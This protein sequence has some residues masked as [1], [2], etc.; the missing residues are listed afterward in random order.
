MEN[1]KSQE[2]A[3]QPL[4]LRR[5]YS[6]PTYQ[7]HATAGGKSETAFKIIILE[8]MSWLRKRFRD[9]DLPEELIAPEPE[10]YESFDLS[11]L[12]SFSLN[13][14]Y[15]LE[16]VWLADENL[17]CLQLTEPDFGVF[18]SNNLQK[19]APVPGRLFESNV[20]CRMKAG[21][22]ELAC[23]TLV[24]EP[25][26]TNESCEV[27]R[28][29]LIKHLVR[30]PLVGLRHLWKLKEEPHTLSDS[31]KIKRFKENLAGD[32]L[33]MPAVVL[34]G[35]T[36][37]GPKKDEAKPLP[38]PEPGGSPLPFRQVTD[39]HRI[40]NVEKALSQAE[41]NDIYPCDGKKLAHETMGYAHIF[42]LPP[43]D[44]EAF[45]K[46]MALDLPENGIIVF[47]PK[48]LG[49][50]RSV[51][52]FD[53]GNRKEL[54]DSLTA[55]L[56]AYPAGK[57]IKFGDCLFVNDAAVLSIEKVRALKLSKDKII[58]RYGDHIKLIEKNYRDDLDN[59][60]ILRQAEIK[61][62][63]S[64][65]EDLEKL[66]GE[67]ASLKAQLKAADK[68]FAASKAN[69]LKEIEFYKSLQYRPQRP[70][71]LADWV[72]GRFDGRLFLHADAVGMLKKVA[73]QDV[74]MNLLCD[75]LE[76]LANEYL[77]CLKRAINEEER[78]LL[79]SQKYNRP[80]SVV[81]N[82][83]AS[84]RQFPAEYSIK[85]KIGFKGKPIDTVMDRHLKVGVDSAKLLRIYFLYDKDK[86]LIVIGSL[87]GHL[88][89]ANQ[90]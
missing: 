15:K 33:T 76:Y 26:G 11:S 62:S 9:F 30:N 83:A 6:Y 23:K 45:A 43:A 68:K 28:L 70:D 41:D 24:H 75:A 3:R 55:Y 7:L 39:Y 20:S 12:K 42:A 27:F 35:K 4:L 19:R 40:L 90:F 65:E 86:Q 47:E 13:M 37:A 57:N 34:C 66:K 31:A 17:W 10:D 84:L 5:N 54:C 80:F 87:P 61:K 38:L 73:A 67:I 2:S 52:D 77:D 78:D 82:S 79:C 44:R 74:D 64:L 56:Q 88:S 21:E 36:P 18:D 49:E 1:Q 48:N 46:A 29:S 60:R 69:K 22:T 53:Q 72:K 32:L 8:T 81:P 58:K 51:Y 59:E 14:G 16:I 89:T 25:E 85:Y 63:R 50:K 71:E